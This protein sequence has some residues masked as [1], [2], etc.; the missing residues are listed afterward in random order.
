[1]QANRI[2][3]VTVIRCGF[4]RRGSAADRLRV[5]MERG[6]FDSVENGERN[7]IEK[8]AAGKSIGNVVRVL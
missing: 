6:R 2:F 4:G 1:M 3:R 5:G 8:N 7:A